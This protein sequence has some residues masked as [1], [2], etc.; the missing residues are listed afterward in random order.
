L[1][2]A[3]W[4]RGRSSFTSAR[5]NARGWTESEQRCRRTAHTGA[6]PV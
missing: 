1:K 3:V 4:S 5:T 6:L 2:R